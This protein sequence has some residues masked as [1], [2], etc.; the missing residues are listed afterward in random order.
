MSGLRIAHPTERSC[1]Y[2]LV[3][4]NRPYRAP[5]ACPV[6][7]VMHVFKTYHITLDGEGAAIVSVE[8]WE[9]MQRTPGGRHFRLLNEVVK[10]PRQIV[11]FR[12]LLR[13]RVVEH[14]E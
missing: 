7:G 4:G 2:T 6:C 5:I 8:V 14:R 13:P 9:R 3:D 10:P 11:G 12:D 1:T